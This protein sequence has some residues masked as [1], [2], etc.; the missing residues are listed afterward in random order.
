MRSFC[1]SACISRESQCTR[2][3]NDSM[4]RCKGKR[5][6]KREWRDLGL[7]RC[8]RCAFCFVLTRKYIC[9]YKRQKKEQKSEHN[10]RSETTLEHNRKWGV[11]KCPLETSEASGWQ[12]RITLAC[13][14]VLV[15]AAA[16]SW[17]HEHRTQQR[18]W[19]TIA[20]VCTRRNASTQK[21]CRV[22]HASWMTNSSR[23]S[24][25]CLR[26]YRQGGTDSLTCIT[27]TE[28]LD[29][30]GVWCQRVLEHSARGS[31]PNRRGHTE[32]TTHNPDN[33]INYP[34]KPN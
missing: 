22:R 24:P 25:T 3:A 27:Y 2:W 29:R 17:A 28:T 31:R 13:T 26:S 10:R 30:R 33:L 5:V 12:W 15:S 20:R 34:T 18:C 14:A 32:H 7:C 6:R 4:D 21:R 11:R 19:W 8:L 1:S 16:W 9:M 23:S